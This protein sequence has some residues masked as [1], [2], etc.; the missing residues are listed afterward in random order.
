MHLQTDTD[1]CAAL[2]KSLNTENHIR[3]ILSLSVRDHLLLSL[4]E[5]SSVGKS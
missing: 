1:L 4:L 2:H 5:L 3:S